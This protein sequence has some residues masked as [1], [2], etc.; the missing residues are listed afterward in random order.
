[1]HNCPSCGSHQIQLIVERTGGNNISWGGAF[2]GAVVG[3]I[4]LG[5]AGGIV[6]SVIGA[7]AFSEPAEYIELNRCLN[8]GNKWNAEVV[9]QIVNLISQLI[10]VELDLSQELDRY[11]LAE[12]VRLVLPKMSYAENA[13]KDRPAMIA[14]A[15]KP[16]NQDSSF[17]NNTGMVIFVVS[18]VFIFITPCLIIQIPG[19]IFGILLLSI[20]SKKQKQ[21]VARKQRQA[22]IDADQTVNLAKQRSDQAIY[23]FAEKWTASAV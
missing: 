17:I 13:R 5:D 16:E 22:I 20:R 7:K 21:E 12:F 2:A 1:M 18:I 10:D 11:C 9:F 4:L 19:I 3:E 23:D 6:G 15:I 14:S 8:C